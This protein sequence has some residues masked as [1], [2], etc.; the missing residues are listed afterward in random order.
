MNYIKIF[1]ELLHVDTSDKLI[2]A[3]KKTICGMMINFGD[4]MVM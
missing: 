1:E 2:A 3:L 4:I